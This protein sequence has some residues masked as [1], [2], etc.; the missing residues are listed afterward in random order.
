L[1]AV[2][3]SN[4]W[5]IAMTSVPANRTA[6]ELE[7]LRGKRGWIVALGV[8]YVIAGLIA[9]GSVVA[10]TAA[11]VFVVGIMMVVAGVA[12]IIN[13]FQIKT[14]GKFLFWL[15][16]GGLYILAGIVT[17][18]NPLLAAGLLTLVLGVSLAVSGIV[19]I[20]L[21]F[22][23]KEGA[24]WI[25][26]LISGVVTLILG[27][28]I[29]ARWPISGLYVLGVFLGIDLVIAGASWIGIGSGLGKRA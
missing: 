25:L 20:V 13:A 24:P 23:L 9:L 5:V 2:F 22:S 18:R 16:L 6:S 8:I 14:W 7:P 4:A 3:Q 26:V 28:M 27:L 11:S 21:A 19:R 17:L 15:V 10:A 12:E 1:L 29:L